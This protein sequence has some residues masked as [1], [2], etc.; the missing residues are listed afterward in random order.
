MAQ[1]EYKA[2]APGGEVVLGEVAADTREAAIGGLRNKGVVPLRVEALRIASDDRGD[3]I[4][5]SRRSGC[6]GYAIDE[7]VGDLWI[8]GDHLLDLT[9]AHEVAVVP[10]AG[11]RAVVEIEPALVVTVP[12]VAAAVPAVVDLLA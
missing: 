9:R 10:D 2:I 1:F 4:L 11:A 3:H 5:L 8:F 7:Y 12:H 6:G